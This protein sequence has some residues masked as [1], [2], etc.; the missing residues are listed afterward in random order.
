MS[1]SSPSGAWYNGLAESGLVPDAVVRF[2]IRQLCRARL[3]EEGAGGVEAQRARLMSWVEEL[4][5]SPIAIE[6][7]AANVQHY[8][9][10]AAFFEGVLGPHLKYSC[11]LWP[12]GVRTLAEAEEA[13]L[14]LTCRRAQLADG[15]EILELGCGWGSLT[16]WMAA[17][18]PAS[19]ILAVSN[20]AG[21]RAFILAR[22]RARGLG[23]VDVVTADINGFATSRRFDRVVSV[24]MFE[25]VRNYEALL[26]R[27]A[28]WLLEG[29]RLFVHI[30]AH[31]AFAYPYV[32]RDATDWMAEHFFTGGQMPSEDL[33]L[34]FQRDL[35][36]VERWAVSGIHYEKTC[37]AWLANMDSRREA[38]FPVVEATYGPQSAA[39]WW[40]R[41]RLFFMACA[42]LFGFR[43]GEE[44]FV[45]H[46]LFE[47]P[48]RARHA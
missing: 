15:H 5:R 48:G 32:V 22:A 7:A 42:E 29:G 18:L 35:A 26:A 38:L 39:R 3:R 24:E 44:W 17:R 40:N 14:D 4:R 11:G 45:S 23:N 16:L 20:S 30:F 12:E 6:T 9:V 36:L 33:L 28:S 13:M 27:I 2:A 1:T 8:E 47:K 43:G 31:R 25:H 41:W 10:P 21:Q 46:A 37:N 19:R 34:H